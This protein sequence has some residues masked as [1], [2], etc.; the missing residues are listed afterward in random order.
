[1]KFCE[2]SELGAAYIQ[3]FILEREGV[4]EIWYGG[5]VPGAARQRKSL[6]AKD[7]VT[8]V[9]DDNL[10]YILRE[11]RRPHRL[12]FGYECFQVAAHDVG[13]VRFTLAMKP[14]SLCEGPETH[15]GSQV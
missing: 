3:G 15:C 10:Q 8:E 12:V 11:V 13:L 4:V 7:I 6:K 9:C 5:E 14:N 2:R 1:M